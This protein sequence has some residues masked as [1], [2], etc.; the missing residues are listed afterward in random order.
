MTRLLGKL[1]KSD[2]FTIVEL[3]VVFAIL[4]GIAG[5]VAAVNAA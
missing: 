2:G 3:L 5:V 1:A 4:A